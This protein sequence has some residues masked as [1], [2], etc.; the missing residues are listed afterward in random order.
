M[1]SKSQERRLAAQTAPKTLLATLAERPDAS[2]ESVLGSASPLLGA[3]RE[4]FKA[5]CA[6]LGIPLDT[7]RVTQTQCGGDWDW[8]ELH[9]RVKVRP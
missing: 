4:L 8:V 2:P 7:F 5:L 3:T 6:E 1:T 9:A